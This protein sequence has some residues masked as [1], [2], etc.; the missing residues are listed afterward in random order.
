M[1]HVNELNAVTQERAR[2]RVELAK[3]IENSGEKSPGGAI[4]IPVP[5][6]LALLRD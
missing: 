6:V 3:I 4:W 5:G 1:T 2:L